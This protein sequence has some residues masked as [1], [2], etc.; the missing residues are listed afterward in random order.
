MGVIIY[1]HN[2]YSRKSFTPEELGLPGTAEGLGLAGL[3]SPI[4]RFELSQRFV[5]IFFI[6]IFPIGVSWCVRTDDT[7]LYKIGEGQL[8]DRLKQMEYSWTSGILSFLGPLM[9]LV[10]FGVFLFQDIQSQK[11]SERIAAAGEKKERRQQLSTI[12]APSLS[13]YYLFKGKEQLYARVMG[14]NDTAILLSPARKKSNGY[15]DMEDIVAMLRDSAQNRPAEWVSKYSLWKMLDPESTFD[16]TLFGTETSRLSKIKRLGEASLE[17]H[18][19]MSTAQSFH[20]SLKNVGSYM[21][22]MSIDNIEGNVR[23][24]IHSFH[25]CNYGDDMEFT[26]D[27]ASFS[28]YITAE[29]WDK[30]ALK[31]LVS[32]GQVQLLEKKKKYY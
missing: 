2:R 11:E 7:N 24:D 23:S 13:D 3:T 12:V 5:H 18:F 4:V 16:S 17:Y 19:T 15:E 9:G 6:P 1:G 30:Y 8:K 14:F 25:G 21:I 10:F 26:T 20:F 32:E 22:I 28:F 27:N 29:S 31:F